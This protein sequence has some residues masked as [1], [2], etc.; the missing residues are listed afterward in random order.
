MSLNIS[1]LNQEKTAS[2]TNLSQLL[3]ALINS[4]ISAFVLTGCGPNPEMVNMARYQDFLNQKIT[5]NQKA[6]D[7]KFQEL[8]AKTKV[9]ESRLQKTEERIKVMN[10]ILE[11]IRTDVNDLVSK[12][13]VNIVDI[14]TLYLAEKELDKKIIAQTSKQDASVEEINKQ[15][16][17][18]HENLKAISGTMETSGK[19]SEAQ[20][21]L[22]DEAK[23]QIKA[24]TVRLDELTQTPTPEDTPPLDQPP[25][26]LPPELPPEP[27][28][29]PE[30][31]FNIDQK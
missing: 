24:L 14:F 20:Q 28:F 19:N 16:N 5:G 3:K 11:F 9:L 12:V 23:A 7:L 4:S 29:M 25:A 13:N 21:A 22:I 30:P 10:T 1:P 15:L 26:D 6:N 31:E 17:T 18:L 8:Q 2:R 27:P